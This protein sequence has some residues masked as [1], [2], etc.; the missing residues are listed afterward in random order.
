MISQYYLKVKKLDFTTGEALIALL[1]EEEAY[2]FGIHA[3]D[4]IGLTWRG[5]KTVNVEANLS[6]KR[7]KP[8][9]IGLYEEVWQKYPVETGEIVEVN[10]LGRPDSIQAIKKKLLGHHLNE[11][12]CQAIINDIVSNRIS[13]TEIT[14][15]VAA[16]YMYPYN[17]DELYYMTKAVAETGDT[18]HFKGQVV[19]KH[20]VGGIAGN[21]TTMV[22]IPI[23]ASLG[24]KIPKTSSRAIT[25]PAGT[26][27]TMEV[28][29]PV[30]FSI[31]ET[32]EIVKK[33]G[34]CLI[35]GGGFNLAP[36]DDRILKVTYPLSL[37]PYDKMIVSVMAKKVSTSVNCL[38]ID[39]P[40]GETA[41]IPDM[42][43]AIDLEKRF[44]Y[45]AK[46]FGIKIKVL[47]TKGIDP[48]GHGIGPSLEARDVLRVLQRKDNRPLDLEEKSVRLAGELLELAGK[49]S[50]GKG[51]KMA[52]EVLESGQAWKKMQ[53]IIK[54]QGGKFKVDSEDI[55][56]GA[57]KHYVDAPRSGKVIKTNNKNINTLC[58]I[59]GAP[60]EKLAGIYLNIEYG[61]KVKKGE[62]MFTLYAQNEQRMALAKVAL[63]K[64]EIFTIK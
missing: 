41:K 59:L 45:V 35:W 17:R 50:K 36:S 31:A 27:D 32:M 61:D 2:H 14:Y 43:T 23:I 3:G 9:E 52:Q 53:E 39:M 28:L 24:L 56:I 8:G 18:I 57:V 44:V 51:K 29:A 20:S 25:S 13:N 47:K 58:R 6:D 11:A 40:V 21:R 16:T 4:K 15:F 62:R 12:D 38:I 10:V 42:A 54:A 33:T 5:K 64:T 55:T 37:E 22:I 1:N 46:Q 34:G 48:I 7:I 26:S 49:A 19:D 60:K 63:E 30:T